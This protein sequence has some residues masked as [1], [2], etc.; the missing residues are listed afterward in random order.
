MEAI[1]KRRS[2]RKYQTKDVSEAVIHEILTAAMCAPSAHNQKPWHFI[3]IKDRE[4]LNAIMKVHPYSKMLK[5]APVA[6]LVC[7]NMDNLMAANFGCKI[8]LQP[9]RICL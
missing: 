3:V 8:V 2:I 6:I 1:S 9:L 7:A 4:K 5:E